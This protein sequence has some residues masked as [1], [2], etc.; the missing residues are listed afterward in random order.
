MYIT[1]FR[2]SA[3]FEDMTKFANDVNSQVIYRAWKNLFHDSYLYDLIIFQ[4]VF[5]KDVDA[6]NKFNY[7]LLYKIV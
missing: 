5:Q 1:L 4:K 6:F 3:S 7:I 2:N